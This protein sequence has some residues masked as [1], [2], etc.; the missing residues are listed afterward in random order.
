MEDI[1]WLIVQTFAWIKKKQQQEA[2][3][4]SGFLVSKMVLQSPL[5]R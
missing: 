2:P 3:K 5:S 1:H 4:Q